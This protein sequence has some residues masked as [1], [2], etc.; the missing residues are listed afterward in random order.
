MAVTTRLGT[1]I[2]LSLSRQQR[3]R[4]V[5][6]AATRGYDVGLMVDRGVTLIGLG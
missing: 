2:E 5:A 6:F 4:V 3:D 1:E